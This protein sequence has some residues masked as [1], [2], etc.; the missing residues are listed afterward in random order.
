MVAAAVPPPREQQRQQLAALLGRCR[1]A[2]LLDAAAAARYRV[3][4]AHT[5]TPGQQAD[6]LANFAELAPADAAACL[7]LA[8]EH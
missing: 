4:F 5:F 1:A 6:D 7:R 8:V 3:A 2:G